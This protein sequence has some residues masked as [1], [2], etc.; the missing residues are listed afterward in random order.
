MAKRKGLSFEDKRSVMLQ[1]MQES[2]E[3]YTLK[4]LEKLG[5]KAGVVQQT[6]EEV[7]KSL[8]DDRLVEVRLH[9]SVWA[10]SEWLD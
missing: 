7:V 8:V 9:V 2:K 1:L 3:V 6:V 5:S 10:P 4:E